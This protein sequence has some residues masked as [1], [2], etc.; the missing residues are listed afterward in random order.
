MGRPSIY[1]RD[2]YR[3]MR[4]RRIVRRLL[5][6]AVILFAIFYASGKAVLP[7][8]KKLANSIASQ[9]KNSTIDNVKTKNGDKST[10]G[11]SSAPDTGKSA[12][13]S[14]AEINVNIPGGA[15]VTLTC[16]K[17]NGDIKLTG[18]KTND[19]STCYSIRDDG[20]AIA[21]DTPATSDIWVCGVDGVPKKI[22]PDSYKSTDGGKEY[23][24]TD[25]MKNYNNNYV[26]AAKPV[27]L[28]DGR[29]LYQSNLPW[30]KNPKNYYLWVVGS[31]GSKNRYLFGTDTTE[32]AKYDGFTGSGELIAEFG[33]VKYSINVN[34]RNKTRID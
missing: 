11:S 14:Q 18:I 31:D 5:I 8:L 13:G 21:F 4:R 9:P 12:A 26:W 2:Y 33:G 10:G 22:S 30:F 28:K 24:K 7:D 32:P 20:K 34:S 3:I 17:E 27:F 25:V 1:S 6:L 16:V 19:S 23:K 15:A 29:V